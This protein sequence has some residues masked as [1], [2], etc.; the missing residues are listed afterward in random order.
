MELSTCLYACRPQT[1]LKCGCSARAGTCQGLFGNHDC[2]DK[3]D[4]DERTTR[5][6]VDGEKRREKQED[7]KTYRDR[8]KDGP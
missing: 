4:D 8:L 3:R 6:L 1:R 7:G 5:Q 2:L